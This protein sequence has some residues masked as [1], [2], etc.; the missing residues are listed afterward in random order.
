MIL[1]ED[2]TNYKTK[3]SLGKKPSLKTY[4]KTMCYLALLP[5]KCTTYEDSQSEEVKTEVKVTLAMSLFVIGVDLVIGF[6]KIIIFSI[7]V[8]TFLRNFYKARSGL[9][10]LN[11]PFSLLLHIF[12][13]KAEPITVDI[14]TLNHLSGNIC[15]K[16][17]LIHN[18]C[19]VTTC[20]IIPPSCWRKKFAKNLRFCEIGRCVLCL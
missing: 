2:T 1:N 14:F 9:G 8:R 20:C 7:L 18:I 10:F 15:F 17:P 5:V 4:I 11:W 3:H 19:E 6:C 12:S 13:V 16:I